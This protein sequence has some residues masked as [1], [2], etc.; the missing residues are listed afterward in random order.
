M[1]RLLFASCRGFGSLGFCCAFFSVTLAFFAISGWIAGSLIGHCFP[2]F[3][4]D[5][6]VKHLNGCFGVGDESDFGTIERS[7]IA[8]EHNNKSVILL[9]NG[10]PGHS[11][12]GAGSDSRC[13]GFIIRAEANS[14]QRANQIKD[15]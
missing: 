9:A 15:A 6:V 8:V 11:P 12:K 2:H 3:V 1:D 10:V 5:G 13:F 7:A 14:G 4:L